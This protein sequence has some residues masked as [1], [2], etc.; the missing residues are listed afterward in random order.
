MV[1]IHLFVFILQILYMVGRGYLKPDLSKLR[2]DIP[3]SFKNLLMDCIK[4]NRDERP[5]F[6]QVRCYYISKASP[7]T[8]RTAAASLALF[9][10]SR[11]FDGFFQ[12]LTWTSWGKFVDTT[13]ERLKL[14]KLPSLNVIFWKLTKIHLLKVAKFYRRLY[15]GG[16]KFV[17]PTIETSVNFC[18]FPELYLRSLKTYYFR[19]W[20]FEYF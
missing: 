18:N 8:A 3:K 19:I 12:L 11:P 7:K 17:P 15:G 10:I 4:F 20:Q 2:T 6:P 5:L 13:G 14:A 1:S 16:G 9:R